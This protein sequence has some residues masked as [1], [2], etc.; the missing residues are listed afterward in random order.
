MIGDGS[1]PIRT[2]PIWWA[3]KTEP[4]FGREVERRGGASSK[5]RERPGSWPAANPVRP[6]QRGGVPDGDDLAGAG[7]PGQRGHRHER[8]A[9]RRDPGRVERV[10]DP[11]AAARRQPDPALAAVAG[12]G[13]QRRDVADAGRAGRRGRRCPPTAGRG[14][15]GPG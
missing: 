13:D 12:H 9:Q 7:G 6:C 10:V 5:T 4:R 8:V 14:R 2:V 15:S 1:P 3:E 11:D